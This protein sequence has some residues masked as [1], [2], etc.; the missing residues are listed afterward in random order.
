MKAAL[1]F[2]TAVSW[3][4]A[5]N[6]LAQAIGVL[7]MP[8]LTRLYLPEDFA[9]QSIF[10]QFSMFFAGVMTWRFEY[11][12]QLPKDDADAVALVRLT[13]SLAL[14]STL[15]LTPVVWLATTH[16]SGLAERNALSK[17]LWL[18]PLTAALISISLAFQHWAQRSG[19]FKISGI[20]EIVAKLGYISMGTLATVGGIGTLGL[21]LTTGAGTACKLALYLWQGKPTVSAAVRVGWNL[22]ALIGVARGHRKLATSMLVSHL[23]GTVTGLAPVL[24]IGV[25]YGTEVLGQYSLV[26]ATI[27]LPSGLIGTAIGQVFYQRAALT[28]AQGQSFALLWQQTFL[29]LVAIGAPIHLLVALLSPLLYPLVFGDKWAAAGHYAALMSVGAF[30]SFVSAPMDRSSLI[31]GRWRYLIYWH[32]ARAST[33]LLLLLGAHL[34]LLTFDIFLMLLVAQ[35]SILYLV[36][37][38]AERCYSKILPG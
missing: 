24:Y 37:L 35:M 5:G 1:T 32:A 27:F 28:W 30:F 11:F 26:V 31:V 20:G 34:A 22:A 33:T 6:A 7:G 16:L 29:K 12:I 10:L 19:R 2:W 23:L 36:D 3:Q 9:A 25:M 4:A 8:L 38:V 21:L 13:C 17:W 18:S 15:L 14:I